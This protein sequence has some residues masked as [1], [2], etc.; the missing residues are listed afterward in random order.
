MRQSILFLFASTALLAASKEVTFHKDVAPVLQARCQECHRPGEAAPFSLLTYKDARPWAKA[1]KTAVVSR[2]M[3]PWFA[4]PAHGK[5]ANDR[6]LRQDEIDLLT[7]WVDGGAKEGNAKDAPKP[8]AFT[9]GWTI[10]KPDLVL[11]MPNAFKVPASGTVEYTW[12]VVP[13]GLAD[14]KWIEAIEVRPG[15]REVVHHAVLY[16]REAGSPFMK[17]AKPGEAFTPPGRQGTPKNAP[18]DEGKGF[19]DFMFNARGVEIQSVYV[20]GGL[21]YTTRPGQARLLKGGSDLV[22][23]MHYTANGKEALDKTKVGIRFAKSAPKERVF[24]TFLANPY[25]Q[26]P[27]GAQNHEVTA[28]VT[29]PMEVSIQ[30][31]FPHTHVRGKAFRY[32]VTY[33]TGE[34]EVLLDLPKYDFNWQL[35]YYLEQPK[36][37]PKG[38]V[39]ECKAW[40]D[41]SANNPS[42]PDPT[43]TVHW[44]DQTWEEMLAGFVD[45]VVPVDFQPNHLVRGRP[46]QKASN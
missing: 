34:K 2:K 5:F 9:D 16:S 13:T 12:I 10:G 38:T 3:P 25:F 26:I 41:N 28:A 7:A 1:I 27:P 17:N 32:T 20:P 6:A 42:N 44:G 39:I 4:N 31:M 45:F 22:F 15:A 33:P 43:K 19:W 46:E 21:A 36:V 29:L 24:N 40:Y 35:T 11:E 37:L 18:K 14:D 23:Q 30:S 8:V